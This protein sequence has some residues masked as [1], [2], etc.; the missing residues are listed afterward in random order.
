MLEALLRDGMDLKFNLK[1]VRVE[2]E[3]PEEEGDFPLIRIVIEEDGQEK[4]PRAA[5]RLPHMGIPML[6]REHW[7][8]SVT[9][10]CLRP[11]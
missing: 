2:S 8:L 11:K 6:I 4:V 9:F 5:P 10:R 7:E 3:L 1:F